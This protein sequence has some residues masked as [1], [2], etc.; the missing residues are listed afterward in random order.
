MI[1]QLEWQN[2]HKDLLNSPFINHTPR[3]ARDRKLLHPLAGLKTLFAEY[4]QHLAQYL[5][6]EGTGSLYFSTSFLQFSGESIFL[7]TR[8][9]LLGMA[10]VNSTP[11]PLAIMVREQSAV[12]SMDTYFLGPPFKLFHF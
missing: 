11:D 5:T 9:S 3:P 2:P 7:V 6:C 4:R 12:R 1:P 8:W 10:R